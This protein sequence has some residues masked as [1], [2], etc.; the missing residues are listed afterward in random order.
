M[1]D[2]HP[3]ACE[4]DRA[5]RPGDD[6]S[7]YGTIPGRLVAANEGGELRLG[8]ARIDYKLRARDGAGFSIIEYTVAGGFDGPAAPHWHTREHAVIYVLE[9]ELSF[10]LAQGERRVGEAGMLHLPPGA[11]FSWSNPHDD[12]ARFLSMW[13]PGGFESFFQDV[14]DGLHERAGS[15]PPRLEDVTELVPPLWR[16]YGI[17]RP[18]EP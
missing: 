15:G 8:P 4:P 3:D 5:T 9:G 6:T 10:Q 16:E 1:K 13:S 7:N 11:P 14:Y 17:E 2:A 18:S 12:P